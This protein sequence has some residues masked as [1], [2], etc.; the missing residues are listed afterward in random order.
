MRETTAIAPANIAFIK[1]WGMRD[2][3]YTLPFHGS[4]SMNLDSCLTT[5]TVAFDESLTD[6]VVTLTLYQQAPQ[7]ATG[8]PRE[9]V[10]EHL[11]RIRSLAGVTTRARVA[12]HNNFPSDAGIASSAAAFAA[13]TLAAVG[14]LDLDLDER[15]LTRLT[16]QSGSG[17]ASRSIP[18]GYVEW[19][20]GNDETSF[21]ETIAPPDHWNLADVV[22]VVDVHAKK[23]GSAQNHLKAAT[24][25]YFTTRLAEVPKRLAMARDAILRCD[26]TLLGTVM[27]ADAVSMHAICMT[28][29]PPSFYWNAGTMAVIHAVQAWREEGLES[30]FTIDAGANVHV[31]C[32]GEH[33]DEVQ[34]RVQQL[35]DVQFTL[36]N[37]PGE[38][39]RLV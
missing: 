23:V 35:P 37:G 31:I 11:D 10:V 28:Q 18:T 3:T 19:H 26:L 15:T 27:E 13:L 6:D 36:V 39:A 33:R 38:G 5:T 32:A 7:Q 20:A 24:S 29:V 1:Y 12:S 4:I 22:A 17:S 16:R 34:Q 30:Y 9:R 2:T 14:A 8:R 21:A 25:P